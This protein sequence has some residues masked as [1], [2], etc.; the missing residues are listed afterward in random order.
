MHHILYLLCTH[1]IINWPADRRISRIYSITALQISSLNHNITIHRIETVGGFC[2]CH[3]VLLVHQDMI[4]DRHKTWAPCCYNTIK[5]SSHFTHSMLY[6]Q[7]LLM[8]AGK[9]SIRACCRHLIPYQ[10]GEWI[11]CSRLYCR[12]FGCTIAQIWRLVCWCWLLYDLFQGQIFDCSSF[13]M[14]LGSL[15]SS[16]RRCAPSVHS[17]LL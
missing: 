16:G 8:K 1:S 5:H 11:Y 2:H 7:W 13:V 9:E 12:R 17:S 10:P 6:P 14:I 3:Q 15:C 4:V